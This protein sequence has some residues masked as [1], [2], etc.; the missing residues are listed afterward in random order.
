MPHVKEYDYVKAYFSDIDK[1]LSAL[2]AY[3]RC[4]KQRKDELTIF[5]LVKK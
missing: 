1:L 3:K 4:A 2:E 5:D